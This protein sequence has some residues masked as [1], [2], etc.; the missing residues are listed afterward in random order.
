MEFLPSG[1][2]CSGR[3]SSV[4]H[5]GFEARC[6]MPDGSSRRVHARWRLGG[7]ARLHGLLDVRPS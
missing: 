6:R 4:R 3:V 7:A 5:F 2:I 1:A